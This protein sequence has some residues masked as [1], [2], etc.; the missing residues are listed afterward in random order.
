VLLQDQCERNYPNPS[1]QTSCRRARQK[2]R[3]HNGKSFSGSAKRSCF[4]LR[5]A[6]YHP[7][8]IIGEPRHQH[9]IQSA[10]LRVTTFILF[11]PQSL[12]L[13]PALK[14]TAVGACI[15]TEESS[16]TIDI[17]AVALNLFIVRRHYLEGVMAPSREST[18]FQ[19]PLSTSYHAASMARKH[20]LEVRLMLAQGTASVHKLP[21][22]KPVISSCSK[23]YAMDCLNTQKI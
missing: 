6:G 9:L 16:S 21:V 19:L 8:A 14:V 20:H 10:T 11:C 1:H 4:P 5:S 7:A 15:Q 13:I 3:C 17:T 23:C 18:R 22:S 12:V 2:A